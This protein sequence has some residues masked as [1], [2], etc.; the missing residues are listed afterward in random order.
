MGAVR[1]LLTAAWLVW[2]IPFVLAKRKSEAAERVDRRAR[3]GVLIQSAGCALVWIGSFW[4]RPPA[5]WRL[6]VAVVIFALSC[7]LSW[8]AVRTLGRQWRLDAGL[9]TEHELITSGPYRLV[10]HPIY[11]SLLGMLCGMGLLVSPLPLFLPALA[12]YL[13][14]TEIRVRTEERLLRSQF[15][16]EF[17]RYQRR[18]PAYLPFL[19]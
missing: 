6:A 8:T 17:L 18:V 1:V 4:A 11:T 3:W 2:L 7:I 13:I 16:D 10:R 12:V 19:K 14:G 15:G 9:S 5:G